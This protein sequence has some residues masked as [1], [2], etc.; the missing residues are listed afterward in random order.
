MRHQLEKEFK[1]SEDGKI[2]YRFM[3]GTWYDVTIPADK[4]DDPAYQPEE[5]YAAYW[6]F[7][8]E[9]PADV[10]VDESEV[11]HIWEEDLK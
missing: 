4:K 1:V 10:N 7:P 3:T 11:D 8:S 5:I 9:L 2:T 6:T